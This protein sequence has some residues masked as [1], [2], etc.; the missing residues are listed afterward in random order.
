MAIS[1]VARARLSILKNRIAKEKLGVIMSSFFS[2][3]TEDIHRWKKYSEVIDPDEA[4]HEID[5]NDGMT[6]LPAKNGKGEFGCKTA[7]CIAGHAL[8]EFMGGTSFQ[9]L[10]ESSKGKRGSRDKVAWLDSY[11]EIEV[12]FHNLGMKALNITGEQADDLFYPVHWPK[13]F[14]EGYE[15]AIEEEK[16]IEANRVVA[17]RI[18]WFLDYEE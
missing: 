14:R 10:V 1:K 18:Q 6:K 5:P 7:G 9:E 15:K 8:M 4:F 16:F 12:S 2:V 3:R 17:S 11:G 13:F